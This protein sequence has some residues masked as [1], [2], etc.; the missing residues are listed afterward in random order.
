MKK[1]LAAICALSMVMATSVMVAEAL[2]QPVAQTYDDSLPVSVDDLELSKRKEIQ[3][4]INENIW[5]GLPTV[6]DDF[7]SFTQS[8]Y[9]TNFCDYADIGS[10]LIL[11]KPLDGNSGISNVVGTVFDKEKNEPLANAMVKIADDGNGEISVF[12]DSE[13]RFQVLG[14]IDGFYDWTLSKDGYFDSE[15]IGYDVCEGITT[16]LTFY[17]SNQ[18]P[19]NRVSYQ[20]EQYKQE[21]SNDQHLLDEFCYESKTKYTDMTDKISTYSFSSVPRLS[22][23]T[24]GVGADN[25]GRGGTA[26]IVGRTSYI[27]HVVPNEALGSWICK[28]TYGMSDSQIVQYYAAQTIAACSFIE[29]TA[30]C[31]PKHSE[32]TVC[33]TSNCQRYDPTTTNTYAVSA[34]NVVVQTFGLNSYYMILLYRPSSNTYDYMYPAYFRHCTGSTKT[35][36]SRPELK[37]VSCSDIDG[38]HTSYS[39]NGY[40][41]CQMG[42]AAMAKN[43]SKYYDILLHYY[44]DCSVIGALQ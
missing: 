8:D 43:G 36:S 6:I 13:G 26:T 2:V 24:V 28:N 3:N 44:S 34:A 14:L 31:D 30:N 29:W 37:S 18:E 16:M 32:Y 33:D 1:I 41:L 27:T 22:S 15:F 21:K 9:D 20:Y 7:D 11:P 23:F 10:T 38:S 19:I 39:G 35:L 17:M 42:A 4:L 25:S 40:G 5:S 12:T